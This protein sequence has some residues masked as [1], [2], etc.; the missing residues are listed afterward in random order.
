MIIEV[1]QV[2]VVTGAAQGL[3][4]A[5]AE[6]LIDRGVSVVLA[7]IAMERLHTTAEEF[8]ARGARV[9]PVITDSLVAAVSTAKRDEELVLA[10]QALLSAQLEFVRYR[11]D[12]GWDWADD[13]LVAFQ[14]RLVT[15]GEADAIP[16]GSVGPYSCGIS[17][18]P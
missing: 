15:L 7:D 17:L 3:G 16:P 9:L 12:R 8:T 11:Q 4:R 5:L 6:R 14:Q 13:M 18:G 10:Y 1:G 2:A